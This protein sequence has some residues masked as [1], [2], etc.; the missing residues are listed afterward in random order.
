M[1]EAEGLREKGVSTPAAGARAEPVR[2][3]AGPGEP[4][5]HWQR[6]GG[7][8]LRGPGSLQSSK[9]HSL[10]PF[11]KGGEGSGPTHP[12]PSLV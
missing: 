5:S 9:W 8:A 2:A 7:G 12:K 10:S 6:R 1:P 3:W 11:T 4:E